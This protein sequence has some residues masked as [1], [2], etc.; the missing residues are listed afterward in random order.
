M[1][2]VSPKAES[3]KGSAAYVALGRVPPHNGGS[4]KCHASVDTCKADE[5]F[6]GKRNSVYIDLSSLFV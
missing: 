4:T 3:F 1:S 5:R 6:V 2:V